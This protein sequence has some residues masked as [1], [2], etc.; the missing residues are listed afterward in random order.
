MSDD[1][2]IISVSFAA[3]S[4]S[5]FMQKEALV[6]LKKSFNNKD[7]GNKPEMMIKTGKIKLSELFT[8]KKKAIDISN[9]QE[10]SLMKKLCNK[11]NVAYAALS[12][13]S[14]SSTKDFLILFK[15]TDFEMLKNFISAA[16]PEFE[17]E[18]RRIQAAER[19]KKRKN[20][21]RRE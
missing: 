2:K 11:F 8:D 21:I 4:A 13:Q 16:V 1:E 12:A 15:S 6:A 18:W 7:S 20:R 17:R 3:D 10:F 5:I 9:K 14:E 19:R